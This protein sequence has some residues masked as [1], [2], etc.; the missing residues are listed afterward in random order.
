V[1]RK[2]LF[3]LGARLPKQNQQWVRHELTDAG[4]R[5]RLVL[6]HL[7]V[8]LPIAAALAAF[9]GPLFIHIMVPAFFLIA[10][11]GVVAMYA[12]DIRVSRLRRNGLEPPD[13]P[14]LGRPAHLSCGVDD[15]G[16]AAAE[17]DRFGDG[18]G[19]AVPED[20]HGGRVARVVVQRQDRPGGQG[21]LLAELAG[22]LAGQ[23]AVVEVR[24]GQDATHGHLRP[25]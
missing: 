15:Q 18:L 23:G 16:A 1:G 6:R 21:E 7:L 11:V 8:T 22:E 10:S 13:D 19:Q 2:L 3:A 14:D 9:P 20:R 24:L 25:D 17:T 12:D 4:W 5:G